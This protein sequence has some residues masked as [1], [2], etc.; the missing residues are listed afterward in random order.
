[1]MG[2]TT[3]LENH[4]GGEGANPDFVVGAAN[5]STRSPFAGPI[6]ATPAVETDCV[7][8]VNPSAADLPARAATR[9]PA[10]LLGHSSTIQTVTTG[11]FHRD[12]GPVRAHH[13]RTGVRI[14]LHW[15]SGAP[16]LW[17]GVTGRPA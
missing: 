10:L 17:R 12:I 7:G 5:T 11:S 15:S 3:Q 4:A 6:A 9:S 14:F 16:W 13:Q 8:S 1:T 2:T